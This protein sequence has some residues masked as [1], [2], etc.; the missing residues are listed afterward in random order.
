[1]SSQSVQN[2]HFSS[3]KC[4]VWFGIAL[5]TKMAQVVLLSYLAH[6]QWNSQAFFALAY[7]VGDTESYLQPIENWI[8][9]GSYFFDNGSTTVYAG[10][11]PYYGLVYGIF[12]S[13][14]TSENAMDA[15][16]VVQIMLEC[17]AI[18]RFCEL[19]ANLYPRK[20]YFALV[21]FILV[22]INL[23]QTHYS[24]QIVPE[25]LATSCLLLSAVYFIRYWKLAKTYYLL[26]FAFWLTMVVALK[27][28]FAPFYVFAVLHFICKKRS[29]RREV[30]WLLLFPV[31]FIGPW[32]VRNA[33]VLHRFVPFQ[34]SITAGYGYMSSTFAM[35]HYLQTIG[36]DFIHWEPSS[37]GS[38]FAGRD[39]SNS[40]FE[41]DTGTFTPHFRKATA[42]SL[43]AAMLDVLDHYS[44]Q[45]DSLLSGR[46]ANAASEYAVLHPFRSLVWNRLRLAKYFV[47]H[48]G[49]G[50]LPI[51]SS[52]VC[53]APWQY[54]LKIVQSG[55]YWISLVLG[56]L[57]LF[58]LAKKKLRF[59]ALWVVPLYLLVLFPLTLRFVEYRYWQCALPFLL[60]GA[61]YLLVLGWEKWSTRRSFVK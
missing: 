57:G 10:R 2:A 44:P 6:C 36:E 13:F 40:S 1:M 22:L 24:F 33:V 46:F 55:L 47:V 12:R 3:Q 25:S 14:S 56:P 15:L 28:Y 4:W 42:D 48:S 35:R 11:M 43:R 54:V 34:E 27:P 61:C 21:L 20:V 19:F 58:L 49:S 32:L 8:R 39:L 31:A 50:F 51:H 52:S 17:Y 53:Y 5:L 30:F 37:A 16:V 9:T 41:W 29:W 26:G 45:K 18:V 60:F 38:F 59:V 7:T 23:Q